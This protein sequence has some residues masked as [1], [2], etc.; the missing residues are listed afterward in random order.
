ML[1]NI[2]ALIGSLIP[3]G[4]IFWYL[5]WI[6]NDNAIYTKD[7]FYSFAGGAVCCGIIIAFS[8]LI[9]YVWEEIGFN[10]SHP[11]L[12]AILKDFIL[13]ALTEELIKHLMIRKS[14]K[15]Y[16]G[17][18]EKHEMIAFGGIVGIGFHVVESI[19]DSFGSDV[20]T[21]LIR[22]F[23]FPHVAYGLLIGWFIAK[24][25]KSHNKLYII[26]SIIVPV[27][28]QG[29]YEFSLSEELRA[30]SVELADV[31][32]VLI[33]SFEAVSLVCLLVLVGLLESR[34]RRQNQTIETDRLILRPWKLS[35][36]KTCFIYASNPLIGPVAGWPVHKSVEESRRVI[37]NVL[38]ARGTYAICLKS[39]GELIGSIGLKFR[40]NTDFTDKEDE[41]EL[42]FW[43]GQPF[44]GNGYMPEAVRAVIKHAFCD[45]GIN[46]IWCG[47]YEGNEKSKR[48]QEKCGFKYVRTV[49]DLY[50]PQM[51]ETRVGIANALT[52]EDWKKSIN[53]EMDKE[54]K[55]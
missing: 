5:H 43:I 39:T 35:D 38:M 2:I 6:N 23:T 55:K 15:K 36:A 54:D 10:E 24:E 12:T 46:K 16:I 37:R 26:P 41:C 32:E 13:L 11:I 31:M 29:L 25:M 45:I 53:D 14:A 21:I 3:V 1:Y 19:A 44:W 40:G 8:L 50:V 42:G 9:N 4:L 20:T 48:V 27:L 49:P 17:A 30:Y 34:Q 47:Y 7:C 52:K 51:H 18:V 22:G 28:F 33:I